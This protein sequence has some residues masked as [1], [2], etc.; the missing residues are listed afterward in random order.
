V[1]AQDGPW[2]ILQVTVCPQVSYPVTII[3]WSN[4]ELSFELTSEDIVF[5]LS[6]EQAEQLFGLRADQFDDFF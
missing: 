5:T 1:T 6:P 4:E 2:A 3:K